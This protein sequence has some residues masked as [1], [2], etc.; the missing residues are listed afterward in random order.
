MT[1]VLVGI[2]GDSETRRLRR[3]LHFRTIFVAYVNQ[4]GL[5]LEV[6]RFFYLSGVLEW[7]L[8]PGDYL[9]PDGGRI[10]VVSFGWLLGH[11]DLDYIDQWVRPFPLWGGFYSRAALEAERRRLLD[12]GYIDRMRVRVGRS[13]EF[14]SQLSWTNP[15]DFHVRRKHEEVI[16]VQMEVVQKSGPDVQ[17]RFFW[18]LDSQQRRLAG[19]WLFYG[20][21]R[22]LVLTSGGVLRT[23]GFSANKLGGLDCVSDDGVDRS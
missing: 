3:D 13:A 5:D 11:E 2:H 6:T 19:R 17:V 1:V 18:H 23:G 22:M 8:T 21:Y 10:N 14:V 20:L 9:F 4:A 12:L 7:G 16:L 15:G